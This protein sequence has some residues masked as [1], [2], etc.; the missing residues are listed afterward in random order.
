MPYRKMPTKSAPVTRSSGQPEERSNEIIVTAPYQKTR[1]PRISKP[2]RKAPLRSVRRQVTPRVSPPPPSDGADS[3][4]SL[5][6]VD[7]SHTAQNPYRAH[8]DDLHRVI[9]DTVTELL[10][11]REKT[12]N[13]EKFATSEAVRVPVTVLETGT[14]PPSESVLSLSK[15]PTARNI[16]FRWP[17]V[18]KE[19]VGLIANGEFD[20]ESLPRLHRMDELRNAYLKKSFKG[21]LQPLEGGPS[22]ILVGTT[23]LQASFKDSTTFFLAWQVYVSIRTTYH[24]ERAAGLAAWTERLYFFIHLNYPWYSILEYV[25][26]Y[27]Q[28][29]QN[30][31]V[32]DW[33]NPDST[34]ISY[35]LTLKQQKLSTAAIHNTGSKSKPSAGQKPSNE[36]CL[37][38]NRPSGCTWSQNHKGEHCPHRHVCTI[39][40]SAQHNAL[41]CTGKSAK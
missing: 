31:P 19:T 17:W 38:F 27:Y 16:L 29:Y 6:S 4:M 23:K 12:A 18:D 25:I 35:H 15:T 20:I 5:E 34:L 28:M 21:I 24:P 2:S 22:E 8:K 10:A 13:P 9:R 7:H 36:I 40:I 11:Q 1:A 30:S 26:A 39:C 33:F 3:E 37:T 32:D 41:S 14:T